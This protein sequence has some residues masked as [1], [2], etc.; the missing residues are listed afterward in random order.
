M[1]ESTQRQMN[2]RGYLIEYRTDGHTAIISKDDTIV[3]CIAGAIYKDGSTDNIIKSKTCI[4][5]IINGT[6]FDSNK[7][8]K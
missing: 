5:C 4:D 3:Q 6:Q 8:Y 2:Y 7:L 1:Y